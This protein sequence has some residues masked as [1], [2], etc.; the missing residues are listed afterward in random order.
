M[1]KLEKLK[2]L[3]TQNVAGIIWVTDN[4]LSK[5][6]DL[7]W[8]MN[9]FFDGQLVR[10]ELNPP[11][12]Q[13]PNIYISNSFTGKIFL[14]HNL[15]NEFECSSLDILKTIDTTKEDG[16]IFVID[17]NEGTLKSIKKKLPHFDV[18]LLKI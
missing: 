13:G 6:L 9:Y 11:S 18:E 7:F 16:R 4:K 1:N 12:K 17:Q 3:I 5:E 14:Y 10:Q 2:T 15:K 8:E